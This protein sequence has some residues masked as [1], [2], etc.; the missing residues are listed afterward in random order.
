MDSCDFIGE[1]ILKFDDRS[2]GVRGN[3]NYLE[4]RFVIAFIGSGLL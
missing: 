3:F 1:N 4:G 2:P